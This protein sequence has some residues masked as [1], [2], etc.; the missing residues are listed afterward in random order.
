MYYIA[1]LTAPQ[2]AARLLKA[3]RAHWTIENGLHWVLD[4]A[5]RQDHSRVRGGSSPQNFTVLRHIAVNLLKQETSTKLGSKANRLKAGWSEAY[6][7]KVLDIMLP[8]I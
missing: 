1:S 8:S 4:I 6:L 7:L 2:L 5:F 3:V